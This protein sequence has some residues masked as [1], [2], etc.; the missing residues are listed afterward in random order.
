[1]ERGG[2]MVQ[3]AV[4]MTLFVSALLFKEVTALGVVSSHVLVSRHAPRLERAVCW[5]ACIQFLQLN[6]EQELEWNKKLVKEWCPYKIF[7]IVALLQY[8]KR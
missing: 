7:Q 2:V 3:A 4:V 8:L 1:M 6:I 5:R